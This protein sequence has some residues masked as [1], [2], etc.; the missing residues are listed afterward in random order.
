MSNV[1]NIGSVDT[2]WLI[3]EVA[4]ILGEWPPT[5]TPQ[6]TMVQSIPG[7]N[8]VLYGTGRIETFD[9]RE[10]EFNVC[11]HDTPY[12]NELINK[13]GMFRTRLMTMKKAVYSWHMDAT[14]RIHIPLYSDPEF[15]FMVVEN[16]V[17]RM[18]VGRI[19]WINTKVPH[20]Y[21]NTREQPRLHIVGCVNSRPE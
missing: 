20:T 14:P 4:S 3:E 18:P 21:V 11:I 7:R 6:Q 17:V 15:N 8:D 19:Y 9:H 16:E 2:E 13:Y 1:V 10:D 12:L 5:G